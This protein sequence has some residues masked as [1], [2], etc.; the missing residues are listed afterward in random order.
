MSAK[1]R[2]DVLPDG[3]SSAWVSVVEKRLGIIHLRLIGVNATK[4]IFQEY[5]EIDVVISGGLKNPYVMAAPIWRADG[6]CG[7]RHR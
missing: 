3:V 6:C 2:F 7:Y 4:V 1:S 5:R